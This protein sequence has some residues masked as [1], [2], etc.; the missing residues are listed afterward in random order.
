[1]IYCE[2]PGFGHVSRSFPLNSD[3]IRLKRTENLTQ[4]GFSLL[5]SGESDRLLG[6]GNLKAGEH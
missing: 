3:A 2:K 1:M 5:R 4:I 6:C